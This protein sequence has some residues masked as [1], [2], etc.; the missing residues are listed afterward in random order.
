[1]IFETE[2]PGRFLFEA[3]WRRR[4]G[5]CRRRNGAAARDRSQCEQRRGRKRLTGCAE[6]L[7]QTQ[8]PLWLSRRP[9]AERVTPR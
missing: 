5:H 1:L 6:Q 9:I 3:G 4:R 7:S 2:N 8:G